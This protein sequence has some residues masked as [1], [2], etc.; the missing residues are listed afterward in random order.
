MSGF[1][2]G[3]EHVSHLM[4]G[5]ATGSLLK[6]AFIYESNISSVLKHKNKNLLPV[7]IGWTSEQLARKFAEM[8][9]WHGSVGPNAQQNR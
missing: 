6:S 2:A 9:R 5:N 1:K 4:I 3:K 7:Q 8:G